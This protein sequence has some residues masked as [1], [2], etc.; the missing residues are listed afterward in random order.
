MD[1]TPL[2]WLERSFE[3]R[4]RIARDSYAP[5]SVATT[6]TAQSDERLALIRAS[7]EAARSR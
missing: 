6:P 3:E 7:K 2:E 4:A 5:D 1:E